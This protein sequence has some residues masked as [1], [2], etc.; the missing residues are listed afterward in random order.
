LI[1]YGI[2]ISRVEILDETCIKAVNKYSKLNLV[3]SP[4][5]FFEFHGSENSIKEQCEAVQE[6]AKE[7]GGSDFVSSTNPEE[8]KKLWKARH[9][10][11]WAST[12]LIPNSKCIVTDVCVPI[13]NL[14]TCISETKKDMDKTKLTYTLVG[15]VGD[16]NFHLI[17][18]FTNDE[19]Y[20]KVEEANERLIH[21][22]LEMSGT[23]TGEHGVSQL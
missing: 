17:I 12:N 4:T 3:E 8:R 6:M 13:S 16:G 20:K 1:Q 2:P 10:A 15:H 7:F 22:A 9:D 11:Y 21:R 14:A 18:L 5:L 19:E 23:C